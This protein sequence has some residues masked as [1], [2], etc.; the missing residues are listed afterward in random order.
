MTLYYFKKTPKHTKQDT[1]LMIKES[2]GKYI[3][4]HSLPLYHGD[5]LRAPLGKPYVD[6]PL[7]IGV[8]H[9]KHIVII[10]IDKDNFGID[11]EDL[12]RKARM[13]DRIAD[14]FFTDSEKELTALSSNK[15]RTFLDIWVKKEAYAKYTGNGL[16]DLSSCDTTKISNFEKIDN[17]K[18]LLIYIYKGKENE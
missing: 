6:Y 18:N 7:H 1:D 4:E 14:K 12:S 11:C 3:S 15:D 17:D 5:I 9:T 16:C 8:T 2:L 10:G 13:R